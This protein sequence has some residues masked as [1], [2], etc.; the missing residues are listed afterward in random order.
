MLYL[1]IG[2]FDRLGFILLLN[3][4]LTFKAEK[5]SICEQL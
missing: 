5:E 4:F 2:L 1:K 3:T